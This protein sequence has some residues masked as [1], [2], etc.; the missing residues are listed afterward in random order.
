MNQQVTVL[1]QDEF[2]FR[3]LIPK[4]SEYFG[5]KGLW[6]LTTKLPSTVSTIAVKESSPI[7]KIYCI[8]KNHSDFMGIENRLEV[9]TEV[10]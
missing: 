8:A 3:I 2:F 10:I 4:E 1:Q 9:K 5:L 7:C 6:K